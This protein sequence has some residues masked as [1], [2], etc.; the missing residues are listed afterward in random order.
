MFDTI[1]RTIAWIFVIINFIIGVEKC[2]AQ[3]CVEPGVGAPP[4]PF[5][6]LKE[7][8]DVFEEEPEEEYFEKIGE[9]W[10]AGSTKGG[11]RVGTWWFYQDENNWKKVTYKAGTVVFWQKLIAGRRLF[12]FSYDYTVLD[13]HVLKL[14]VLE[15]SWN[16]DKTM[17]WKEVDSITGYQSINEHGHFNNQDGMPSNRRTHFGDKYKY[18]DEF[19]ESLMGVPLK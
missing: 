2:S 15:L 7:P 17:E 4:L 9:G 19:D 16:K 11:E 6:D 8:K 10:T 1:L 14:K 13:W 12:E 3:Q 18:G 5:F